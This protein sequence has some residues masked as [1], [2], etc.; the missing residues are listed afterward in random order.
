K[1]RVTSLTQSVRVLVTSP[2]TADFSILPA[3][4][5][6][7][8]HA[9]DILG[10]Q[11][12]SYDADGELLAWD[13]RFGDGSEAHGERVLH[14]Y[15]AHGTYLVWLAVT[16]D[17]G[18][19]AVQTQSITVLSHPPV[20]Q[21]T[22]DPAR[23][24]QGE[25]A[26]FDASTSWDPDGA[27][28]SYR[29]DFDNDG[30][31]DVES[32]DPTTDHAFAESGDHVVTLLVVDDD[33]VASYSAD[34][35]GEPLSGS[36]LVSVNA[37]PTALFSVSSF[38]PLE[39][40]TVTFTDA[41]FDT[42]GIVTAWKWDF[43]DGA[44]SDEASPAH[45]YQD[46]GT[47]TVTLAVTDDNGAARATEARIRV[48][49]LAPSASLTVDE[50]SKP[51]HTAF[52]F[53]ASASSDPSPS[54]SIVQYE[55]D[56]D[57]DSAYDQTTTSSSV[58]HGYEDDGT[59]VVRCRV[60]DNANGTAVSGDLRL[61]VLNQPPRVTRISW[62]PQ[63]PVDGEDV[64][65]TGTGDDPDG[66]VVRWFWDFGDELIVVG[67]SASKSFPADET[68][69]ITL[70]VEDDDGARSHPYSFAL[71][72]ANAPPL[73]LFS[74]VRLDSRTVV[75]DA[76]ESRDPSPDGQIVHVAWEFGDGATCPG[77]P[78]ACG[79]VGRLTPVHFYSEPGTYIVTLV[80]V[81]EQGA[82]SRSR[83]TIE[84]LE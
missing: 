50:P 39:T 82:L 18:E 54:G 43:G 33:G 28:A 51:T 30:R 47:L 10:F 62:T 40:E 69:T 46:A 74:A 29:W 11:D 27:V 53:D 14:A 19:N 64:S 12:E 7:G 45:V 76:R 13:W 44:T 32:T 52:R 17:Q 67:A 63:H 9:M 6:R 59:Y 80:V 65:F 60:T 77:T 2:P 23:P 58:G 5:D 38:D 70:A 22:F 73:A 49:N 1:G 78:S 20:S 34:R 15:D 41:S 81:D 57:G 75:F 83:E 42:D 55:W 24:N 68:F 72:I 37:S 16:D 56:F 61:I 8:L 84:I 3:F 79:E 66:D 36:T 71:T 48:G 25:P 26:R 21:F 31:I 35:A 4:P